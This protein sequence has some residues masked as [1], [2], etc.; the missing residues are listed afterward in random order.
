MRGETLGGYTKTRILLQDR[1]F[2][3]SPEFLFFM[4]DAIEKKNI[5]SYNRHVAPTRAGI[6]LTRNMVHDGTNF[7]YNTTSSVPHTIRGSYAH[8]RKHALNL[9]C[10]FENLGSPQLF[11]TITCNDFAP[12][13]QQYDRQQPWDDPV[14]FATKFKRNFQELFN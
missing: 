7:L 11:L 13:Y 4:M 5:H 8:K 12:E 9:H 3:Q 1:R 2:G 6:K 10:I 14:M